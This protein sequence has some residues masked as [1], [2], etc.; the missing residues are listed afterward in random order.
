MV[1]NAMEIGLILGAFGIGGE[2]KVLS[3]NDEPQRFDKLESVMIVAPGGCGTAYK[4]EN[5]RVHKGHALLKLKGIENRSDAE[6]L[7][8]RYIS[9]TDDE[10]TVIEVA[11]VDRDKLI[12]LNVKT[13]AGD[14]LGILE[15]VIRTGANDVYEVIDGKKSILLP[16]ISD[17]V[18]SIDLESGVMVVELLP[19]L[20]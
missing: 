16:A 15:E 10:R 8:D 20:I 4:L 2:V 19:G 5:V 11:K 17:V 3:L 12:G 14:H 7:K 1:D 9:V 18:K 13:V 6:A